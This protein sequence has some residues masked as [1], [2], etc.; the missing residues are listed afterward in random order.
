MQVRPSRFGSF[1][2]I[3]QSRGFTLVELL[4]V[5]GIIAVL[6]GILL[7]VISHVRTTAYVAS[8]QSRIVVIQNAIEAYRQTFEAYP[9]PLAD[10]QLAPNGTPPTGLG[11]APT[12]SENLV[13]G[14]FGGLQATQQGGTIN[15]KYVDTLVGQGPLSLN[16]LKTQ[17]YQAFGDPVSAG[18]DTH[19]VG[20]AWVNWA[21]ASRTDVQYS[22][23][24]R[25]SII[26][27]LVDAFP[28]PMPILYIRAKVGATGVVTDGAKVFPNG[29]TPAYDATQLYPYP[30]SIKHPNAAVPISPDFGAL[31]PYFG[32]LSDNN[33]PRQKDGYMLIAAGPPD[34]NGHRLYG[35]AAD[36]TNTGKLK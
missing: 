5:I 36:I 34:T 27:E 2:A 7:P 12:S 33:K 13:L 11:F 22:K 1:G 9:G 15:Y 19:K 30:F 26:P 31:Q 32:T 17:R 4:V 16:P 28:N 35:T 24:Y 18:L 6:V 21:D 23:T 25:D 3:R 8:T 20:N 14:L 29:T 10:S